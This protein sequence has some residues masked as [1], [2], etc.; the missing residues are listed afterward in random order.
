MLAVA[1]AAAVAEGAAATVAIL[2]SVVGS[3]IAAAVAFVVVERSDERDCGG[4]GFEST[5][6]VAAAAA[7]VEVEAVTDQG[8]LEG[9]GTTCPWGYH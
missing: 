1:A 2:E 9:L 8:L 3:E 4:A 7:A 5:A 6:E